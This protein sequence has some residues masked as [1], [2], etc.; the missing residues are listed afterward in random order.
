MIIFITYSESKTGDFKLFY[1]NEF[2]ITAKLNNIEK[3]RK[4]EYILGRH[5]C[6]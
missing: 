1:I 3:R 2:E 6:C 5:Y 4:T